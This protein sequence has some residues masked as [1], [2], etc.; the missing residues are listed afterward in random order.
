MENSALECVQS[1]NA[2]FVENNLKDC[3]EKLSD[4][5]TWQKISLYSVTHSH[6]YK[7]G[8]LVRIQGMIQDMHNPEYYVSK[9]TVCN[10]TTG[11]K[12]V[13]SG[14]YRDVMRVEPGESARCAKDG[15]DARERQNLFCIP[16]PALNK[17]VLDIHKQNV[18]LPEIQKEFGQSQGMKR[19]EMD[20]DDDDEEMVCED[21]FKEAKKTEVRIENEAPTSSASENQSPQNLDD[22]KNFSFP[23]KNVEGQPFYLK[24]Y[25]YDQS[26]VMNSMVEVVGFLSADPAISYVEDDIEE[27]RM[28]LPASLIPR[29]HVVCLKNVEHC[30]PLLPSFNFLSAAAL[31]F[32]NAQAAMCDLKIIFTPLLL[33]DKLA[34]DFLI[35][36]L[37]SKVFVR[38]DVTQLGHLSLNFHE[39]PKMTGYVEK[40]YSIL[41]QLVTKSHYFPLTIEG[42][43][44]T[45]FVPKKDYTCDKL[46]SGLLQLSQGTFL[47]FDETKMTVGQLLDLG[48]RNVMA[49]KSFLERQEVQYDFQF[50]ATPFQTDLSIIIFSEKKS[51][52]ECDA[53]VPLESDPEAV[54]VLEASF[55]AAVMYLR[56]DEVITRIRRFLTAAQLANYEIPEIVQTIVQEDFVGMRQRDKNFTGDDLHMM[57]NLARLLTLSTGAQT[58]TAEIWKQAC[59]MEWAR[60]ARL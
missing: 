59:A 15:K 8:Q 51:L 52:F 37:L 30:N 41:E 23:I 17:W 60:R 22:I 48:T 45:P 10:K 43:N 47:V 46:R 56:N 2:D 26:T 57:L 21:S 55:E 28:K 35:C 44:S 20:E 27:N 12:I 5:E 31:A 32:A 24:V 39:V 3:L 6:Q 4:Y 14:K 11:T 29:L 34:V 58:L 40:F 54:K 36:N 49:L 42:L 50:Y 38:K 25:E 33:G 19:K 9:Y 53:R 7:E 18:A 1:W 13:R 16:I